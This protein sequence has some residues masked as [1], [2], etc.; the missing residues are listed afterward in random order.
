MRLLRSLLVLVLAFIACV[1]VQL[2]NGES[3][4]ALSPRVP[5]VRLTSSALAAF[6]LDGAGVAAAGSAG[7]V[8]V[9]AA[10]M[11][12]VGGVV[13][14]GFAI[15]YGI[16]TLGMHA[17][18]WAFGPEHVPDAD[19]AVT[20][21][22]TEV[23]GGFVTVTATPRTLNGKTLTVVGDGGE[24]V[25]HRNGAGQLG[26]VD[27]HRWVS[28]TG[29]ATLLRVVMTCPNGATPVGFSWSNTPGYALVVEGAQSCG[30]G[31]AGWA[32]PVKVEVL[33]TLQSAPAAERGPAVLT[34]VLAQV[35][36]GP[37]GS[38][39]RTVHTVADCKPIDGVGAITHTEAVSGSFRETD[40]VMPDAPPAACPVGSS[41]VGVH[42]RV[43]SPGLADVGLADWTA[44]A[45]LTGLPG[46]YPDCVGVV[47]ELALRRLPGS[48]SC[49]A[50]GTLCQGWF[51]DPAKATDYECMFGRYPVALVEC[52]TLAPAFE[53]SPSLGDPVTGAPTLVPPVVVD[54]A[55]DCPPKFG[56][57][58][59]TP[60]WAYK[61]VGCALS[62]A[63]VPSAETM[64]RVKGVPG[65]LGT[66]PPMVWVGDASSWVHEWSMP[67]GVPAC[68]D[69][70]VET[71][72]GARVQVL[73]GSSYGDKLMS[74][75][76]LFTFFMLSLAFAPLLRSLWYSVFPILSPV[77]IS[78]PDG[79]R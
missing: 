46:L 21:P 34:V 33:A 74:L 63:F 62:A 2:G 58:M 42:T 6:G 23:F 77:P 52:T 35:V 75:R 30:P 37:V 57:S 41:L 40:P 56:L 11:L 13:A 79:G 76:P 29:G 72:G 32:V 15:G 22:G 44:P 26:S 64:V 50:N 27:V 53:P 47:C 17:W 66:I 68:P 20:P 24:P 67:S 4:S 1:T 7:V 73:C 71:P 16:G 54:P 45:A 39:L 61:A 78:A 69:W 36:P 28:S 9:G 5:P 12:T 49:A 55:D 25:V 3:A 8:T 70:G 31:D 38:P 18:S 10:S 51:T 59:L 65:Q 60:W 43:V 19:V 14:D 48:V